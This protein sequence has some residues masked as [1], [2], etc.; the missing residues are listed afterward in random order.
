MRDD[1]EI[2]G[3]VWGV[4]AHRF[5]METS[6]G[7][8]LVDIG[9]HAHDR[10]A[11]AEGDRV[12]V[13][14]ERKPSEIKARRLTDARGGVHRIDWPPKP[15]EKHGHKHEAADPELALSAARSAGFEPVGQPR[16]KPK[17]WEVDARRD[18][19]GMWELH[20]ELDG[21]IR[22]VKPRD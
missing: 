9:P 20:I 1:V 21:R 16:R 19:D 12:S 2:S 11:L 7:K 13:V 4:F 10:I 14:G 6:A 3:K 18:G 22:K 17:H 5:A 8:E 15:H